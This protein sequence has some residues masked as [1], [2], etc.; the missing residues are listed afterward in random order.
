M[1]EDKFI[2]I[3]EAKMGNIKQTCKALGISRQCYYDNYKI[4][5]FK[6]RVDAVKEGL[7]DDTESML[8]QNIFEGKE[9]SIFFYLKTQAKHRGYIE[10][11]EEVQGKPLRIQVE[12]ISKS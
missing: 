6:N 2:E 11:V 4:D 1:N 8:Y 7:I 9:S 12:R 10:K 3:F 5:T